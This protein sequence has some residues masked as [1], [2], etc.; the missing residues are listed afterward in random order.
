MREVSEVGGRELVMVIIA[1]LVLAAC[2]GE[3]DT[4]GDTR[5]SATPTVA[6]AEPVGEL[7]TPA[8]AAELFVE[9]GETPGAAE[10][11][12]TALRERFGDEVLRDDWVMPVDQSE[13][14]FV[15]IFA[16]R[17]DNP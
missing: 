10:C 17:D 7:L 15:D 13:D 12:V 9:Q 6:A 16:C 11:I 14:A 3:P 4:S 8:E 1:T 5:D 2:G